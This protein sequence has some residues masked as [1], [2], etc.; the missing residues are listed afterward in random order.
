MIRIFAWHQVKNSPGYLSIET[1]RRQL[2]D[3]E[4]KTSFISSIAAY[5]NQESTLLTFDDATVDF[6]A[7][8]FPILKEK[9]IPALLAVPTGWILEKSTLTLEERLKRLN[10]HNP[11]YDKEVFC[12][13]DELLKMQ[14]SGLIRFASHGHF[15]K[16]QKIDPDPE[17]FSLSLQFFQ[18]HLKCKPDTFIFPYG[19][20]SKTLLKE[21]KQHYRYLVRIGSCWNRY[22]NPQFYYRVVMD[23]IQDINP[24][25]DKKTSLK[26]ICKETWNRLRNR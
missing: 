23:K 26:F 17:E 10:S 5:K 16:N 15:H 9:K 14:D 8:I 6:Y 22:R 20:F 13:K 11:F 25:F 1:F 24:L 7:N 18:T 19:A 2:E 21:A 12:T 3:L 4:K